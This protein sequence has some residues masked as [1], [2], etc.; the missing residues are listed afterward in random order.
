MI[1]RPRNAC[2]NCGALVSFRQIVLG[3]EKFAIKCRQCGARLSKRTRAIAVALGGAAAATSA[4]GAYGYLSWQ[5]VSAVA[6]A[7][8]VTAILAWFT[9]SVKLAGDDVPDMP[10]IKSPKFETRPGPPPHDPHFRGSGSPPDQSDQ[11]D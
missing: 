11:T 9:V 8:A 10:P 7:L 1:E 4:A 3:A 5:W 6:V 2:P